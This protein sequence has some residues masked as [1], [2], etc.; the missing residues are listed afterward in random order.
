M[1]IVMI[2]NDFNNW[3]TNDGNGD[4][5]IAIFQAMRFREPVIS[6]NLMFLALTH[7]LVYGYW[8]C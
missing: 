6:A 7:V 3:D 1:V 4:Q 5:T 2:N 8:S